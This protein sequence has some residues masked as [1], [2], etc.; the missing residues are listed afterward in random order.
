MWRPH[1]PTLGFGGDRKDRVLAS[2]L[3]L[4]ALLAVSIAIWSVVDASGPNGKNDLV[5]YRCV[6]PNCAYAWTLTVE[7]ASEQIE[8]IPAQVRSSLTGVEITCPKCGRERYSAARGYQ[9]PQRRQFSMSHRVEARSRRRLG[10]LTPV[11]TGPVI[12]EHCGVDVE[13]WW[14]EYRLEISAGSK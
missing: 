11:R 8:Q 4:C 13:K 3:L 1:L 6:D 14:R 12:C 2:G 7:E 9:C 10:V 5:Y